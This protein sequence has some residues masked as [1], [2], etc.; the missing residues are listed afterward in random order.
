MAPLPR[1][2]SYPLDWRLSAGELRLNVAPMV[3]DQLHDF[4]VPLWSGLVTAEGDLRDREVSGLGTLLL[5]GYAMPMTHRRSLMPPARDVRPRGVVDRRGWRDATVESDDA[6][7]LARRRVPCR[8]RRSAPATRRPDT[9]RSSM[10][11]TWLRPT[12]SR[13]P[14]PEPEDRPGGSPPG[15]RRSERRASVPPHRAYR[16]PTASRSCPRTA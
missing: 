8:R 2:R 13:L 12:L 1:G 16:T 7:N 11:R 14:A 6:T 15:T 3:D 4:V 9:A 10:R 5:T